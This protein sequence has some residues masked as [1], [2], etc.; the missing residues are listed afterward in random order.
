M[1]GFKKEE[2]LFMN[3]KEIKQ[4]NELLKDKNGNNYVLSKNVSISVDYNKT[5]LRNIL[6]IGGP[7]T[8]ATKSLIEPNLSN[9]N[10]NF[11][12]VDYD[13]EFWNYK[14]DF[15]KRGYKI[16]K[17]DLEGIV[18]CY[19]PFMHCNSDEDVMKIS[20]G[21][22]DKDFSDSQKSLLDS[23]C[24]Y[25]YRNI[26]NK[27]IKTML[28]LLNSENLGE[29]IDIENYKDVE[30]LKNK[31]KYLMDRNLYRLTNTDDFNFETFLKEK[32]VIYVK[33]S[34]L[35]EKINS[36]FMIFIRQLVDFLE[37]NIDKTKRNISIFL[38]EYHEYGKKLDLKFCVI[39]NKKVNFVIFISNLRFLKEVYD[40][41]EP[42]LLS[43]FDIVV[44]TGSSEYDTIDYISK[45]IG[46]SNYNGYVK[47]G[48]TTHEIKDMSVMHCMVFLKGKKPIYD[49]KNL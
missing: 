22:K 42:L 11:L 12:I 25:V 2:S 15:E 34:Y 16:K 26:H 8:G 41:N 46:I 19:N 14:N 31:F 13:D 33:M 44:Y 30:F 23:I 20:D 28:N 7:G 21:L 47:M 49:L 43:N 27:S 36:I 24:L 18:N 32:E 6:A 10:Q 9:K 5:K 35:N 29:K 40:L 1:F 48:M 3:K 17:I 4:L 37:N 38:D 45:R 39:K